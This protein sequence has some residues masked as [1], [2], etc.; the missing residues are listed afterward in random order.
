MAQCIMYVVKLMNCNRIVTENTLDSQ[1][2]PD[3]TVLEF[4][5]SLNRSVVK[6]DCKLK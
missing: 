2:K 6:P 5:R 1:E 4:T 3:S